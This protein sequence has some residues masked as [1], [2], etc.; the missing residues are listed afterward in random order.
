MSVAGGTNTG[1]RLSVIGRVS[2]TGLTGTVDTEVSSSTI[3]LTS[4][5][6]VD[7]IGLARNAADSESSI[8]E[9]VNG[10]LSADSSKQVVA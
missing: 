7:F 10:A 9:C 6:V 2:L 5:D 1:F 8:V 4:D 3:A